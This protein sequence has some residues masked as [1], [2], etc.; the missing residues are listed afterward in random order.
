[1]ESIQNGSSTAHFLGQTFTPGQQTFATTQ[2]SD[3]FAST[4]ALSALM[5]ARLKCLRFRIFLLLRFWGVP[6]IPSTITEL[7]I[8]LGTVSIVVCCCLYM[9]I[10]V[11]AKLVMVCGWSVSSGEELL[12]ALTRVWTDGYHSQSASLV[13]RHT[14]SVIQQSRN[15]TFPPTKEPSICSG[16]SFVGIDD[17]SPMTQLWISSLPP[18]PD[19]P[20]DD[21]NNPRETVH[22]VLSCGQA[23]RAFLVCFPQRWVRFWDYFRVGR[24]W[25]A[26]QTKRLRLGW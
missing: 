3:P 8:P 15:P 7:P 14:M 21:R 1:M 12:C 17:K 20:S 16:Q 18:F 26:T 22:C 5:D 2:P 4:A 25:D 13:P 10:V 23:P 9:C 11:F 24:R 6:N 19:H